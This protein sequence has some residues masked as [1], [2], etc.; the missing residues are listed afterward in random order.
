MSGFHKASVRDAEVAGRRVLVRVDFNV[1]L[2]GGAV[3]D[4]TR[5]RAALPTIELLRE[6]GAALVLVSHLGRPKGEVVPEL[7][8]RPVGERL[9]ELLGAPVH[10]AGAVVGGDVETMVGGLGPGEMLLL[11]NVRFEPGETENDPALAAALAG[12]ADLYVNDAFGAAHRAH[13]STAGV[14][15]RLP[16]YAGLLLEREVTELTA[17]VEAPRRPLVVVLGGA[18]VTDKI[19]VI[20]RFLDVADEILIGG[21]MCFS[22]ARA[23]GLAVGDSLVEEEGVTLAGEALEKAEGSTCELRLPLDL[24]LGERFAADAEPRQSD[25]LEV[26]DGW[27][28]LDVG[29][30]TAASYA[31]AIGAAGTVLWNGPMGAFELE[32]FAAGTRVVAEAVAKAS[33]TTVVGGG[34]S[35]AALQQFGLGEEVD[36]LSTGGGASLELLEGRK[37]PGV[38][39]LIDA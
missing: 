11:E 16:G 12:L 29:P 35:V 28:G 4:D 22:F 20:D 24:V 15:A 21:A 13:A 6:R 3:A 27:M 25:G 14:A 9:A 5:I 34:D 39:A 7:S 19:G 30:E 1:P 31:D 23:Q 36:W 26:P 37:L 2:E 10:Q 18:K 38:E 17:V 33:G 32:P 8:M